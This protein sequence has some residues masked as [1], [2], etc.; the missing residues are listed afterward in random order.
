M[1]L[2]CGYGPTETCVFSVIG[3]MNKAGAHANTIGNAVGCRTWITNPDNSQQLTPIG[4]I[5]EL[6]IDG[7]ILANGY[8]NDYE[9]TNTVFIKN[10]MW[11]NSKALGNRLVYKT[12]DLVQYCSDGKIKYIG[13]KD[14]QVKLRGQR[15][16][17]GEIEQRIRQLTSFSDVV[18]DIITPLGIDQHDITLLAFVSTSKDLGMDN[19]PTDIP[20][21]QEPQSDAF[22]STLRQKLAEFLPRYMIPTIFIPL[23]QMPLTTAGKT[24]RKELHQQGRF[25]FEKNMAA[26]SHFSPGDEWRGPVSP[27]EFRIRRLWSKTLNVNGDFI[28]LDDDFFGIGGDS[29]AAMRLVTVARADQLLL[30]VADIFRHSTLAAMAQVTR[31][32]Y[33]ND[34][35]KMKLVPFSL[36]EKTYQ[37][38]NIRDEVTS[39][40]QVSSDSV[41]DIYPSTALQEGLLALS[42]KQPGAYF[43][44]HT[45]SLKDDVD[46]QRFQASWQKVVQSTPILRTR[47]VQTA[48]SGCFQVVLDEEVKWSSTDHLERYHET[49]KTVIIDY[50]SPL[51]EFIYVNSTRHFIIRIHHALYD[52]WSLPLILSR[53]E[54][55]YFNE[56][57]VLSP[58]F[59]LFI[60][61]IGKKDTAETESFWRLYLSGSLPPTFPPVPAKYK[62]LT[63]KILTKCISFTS[64]AL[65]NV[66]TSTMIH[67]AWAILLSRYMETE[68]VVFGATLSGRTDSSVTGIEQILGPTITTVPVRVQVEKGLFVSIS[69]APCSR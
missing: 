47:I 45:F 40:C 65:S 69:K 5:G 9:K 8:L 27:A 43:T 28:G 23:A 64:A 52:G 41:Q 16:E 55:A 17:L 32:L 54:N 35:C 68:N 1:R 25:W 2:F 56:N 39:I 15:V 18:V 22:W 49:K 11:L 21:C 44:R 31:T 67:A 58:S 48:S 19:T 62:P 7:P 36:L 50:G 13:R 63:D 61:H 34:L 10:P 6:I 14:T 26:G 20:N 59:G 60:E 57:L 38:Q 66:T 42:I 4:V 3:D 30:S 46:L 51:C 53:V 12:G 29:I 33:T 24:N 37:A